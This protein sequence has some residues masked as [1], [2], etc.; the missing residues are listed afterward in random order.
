MR[1]RCLRSAIATLFL[2]LVAACGGGA[3]S[4]STPTASPLTDG[5]SDHAEAAALASYSLR[6]VPLPIEALQIFPSTRRQPILNVK[7]QFIGTMEVGFIYDPQ[8]E[9]AT[10]LSAPIPGVTVFPL[11]LNDNGLVAGVMSTGDDASGFSWTPSTGAV[12]FRLSQF[13]VHS[14]FIAS[15][16]LVGGGDNQTQDCNAYT[17]DMSTRTL[18]EYPHFC[19]EWMN[20]S[21]AMIGPRDGVLQVLGRDGQFRTVD[22]ALPVQGAFSSFLTD[23]GDVFLHLAEPSG[24]LLPGAVFIGPSGPVNVGRGLVAAPPGA[25]LVNENASILRVSSNG[26][27]IGHVRYELE[28]DDRCLGTTELALPFLWSADAGATPLKQDGRTLEIRDVNRDGIV[29]GRSSSVAEPIDRYAFVFTRATGIV[30]L[31]DLVSNL[32]DGLTLSEVGAIGDGGHILAYAQR[33]SVSIGWA[34]LTPNP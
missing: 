2:L 33:G 1:P 8:T 19:M 30:R 24:S 25:Q 6:L 12:T 21:G 17:W 13:A 18:Q 29:I 3:G 7:G 34:L 14:A 11:A 32:P 4:V 10:P 27:A 16:G 20:G 28:F 22:A 5:A 26:Q 31:D 23:E 9:T 15:D